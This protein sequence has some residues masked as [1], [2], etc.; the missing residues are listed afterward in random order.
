MNTITSIYVTAANNRLVQIV[1]IAIVT[2]TIFGVLRAIKEKKFNSCVGINGAIRKV[3]MLFSIVAMVVID[4]LVHV[5]LIAF[6]PKAAREAMN[7]ESVGIT[8]FF[9]ILYIAYETVSILKNM[10]LCGLPVKRVWEYVRKVLRRYT[11]ELPAADQSEEEKEETAEEDAEDD[12][13]AY[14]D[15]EKDNLDV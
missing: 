15:G 5:N 7:I 1:V 4:Y 14:I 9:A 13:N 6:I 8:E 2:D 10:V 11:E 3:A 12:E